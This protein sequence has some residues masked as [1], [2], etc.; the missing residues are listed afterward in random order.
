MAVIFMDGF[1]YYNS[2]GP[3]GRKY[4][5]GSNL[6]FTGGRFGGQAGQPNTI[7][8]KTFSASYT[9]LVMGFAMRVDGF[10]GGWFGT[11]APPSHPF[12]VFYQGANPQFSVWFDPS[13]FHVKLMTRRGE[14]GGDVTLYDTPFVPPLTLWY[15]FE[16][17]FNIATGSFDMH[18]DGTSIGSG[19]VALNYPGL[20]ATVNI[21]GINV[22]NN[23]SGGVQWG[24]WLCDDLY[25][26]DPLTGTDNI[27][28]LGEVR[29]QTKVPDADGY[30]NDWLRSQGLVNAAN[31]NSLPVTFADTNYYNYSGTVGAVDLYSIQN[32]TV[33]GTI[34]AVQENI[35]FKKDDVGNR[36]VATILRTAAVN[37]TGPSSSC[38]SNY[39]YLGNIWEHN[40]AT[41]NLW[42]LTDLNLAEFGVTVAA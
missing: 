14:I 39:T 29:I 23:A 6:G 26:L 36:N 5:Q 1:D 38:Y 33:S 19:T 30:Q 13:D 21:F 34:F 28:F 31:V 15:Y 35:A 24:M 27:D 7:F 3:G 20:P 41:G 16:I 11:F 40:P 18:V 10:Q 8:L 9:E 37:Y 12:L 42:Q 22:T 2:M 17:K 4:D 25:V 32:F